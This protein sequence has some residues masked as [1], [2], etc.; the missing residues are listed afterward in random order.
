[1]RK[2]LTAEDH[3]RIREA[4]AAVEARTRAKISIVITRVS[5]RYTPYTIAWAALGALTVGGV[6]IATRPAISGRALIFTELCA[7]VLLTVVLDILP[8]RLAVVPKSVKHATA[9]GL[10]HREFAAHLAGEGTHPMRILLF[11]SL[12]ERYVEIIADHETHATAPTGTW[13]RFVDDLIAAVKSGR[14]ADGIVAAIESCGAILPAC[15]D[16]SKAD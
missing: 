5:D 3:R 11:V 2:R 10:A 15:S 1:M 6:A 13:H 9:R 7:L 12:G 16:S 14:I 8:I 4:A